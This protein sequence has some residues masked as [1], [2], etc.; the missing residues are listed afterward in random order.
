MR[1]DYGSWENADGARVPLQVARPDRRR[2]LAWV[3]GWW[4]LV[5]APAGAICV[6]VAAGMRPWVWLPWMATV[7][8]AVAVAQFAALVYAV[9]TW[10]S[11][12]CRRLTY[13][14]VSAAVW[15]VADLLIVVPIG[16]CWLMWPAG[17]GPELL[18]RV[19]MGV[20]VAAAALDWRAA[21][22][23]RAWRPWNSERRRARRDR[24]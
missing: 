2:R 10:S 13:L 24:S 14:A 3:R 17:R 7:L 19:L 21:R 9:R 20:L 5:V 12:D 18:L 22:A 4:S 15:F 16:W 1:H 6:M 8:V 11:P 23:T